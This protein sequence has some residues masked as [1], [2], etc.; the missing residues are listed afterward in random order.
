MLRGGRGLLGR[1]LAPGDW[2]SSLSQRV[3]E[4]PAFEQIL[5]RR[6]VPFRSNHGSLYARLSG[7]WVLVRM[8]AIVGSRRGHKKPHEPGIG[9]PTSPVVVVGIR[10]PA[11]HCI[12]EHAAR[13]ANL[14]ESSL[15]P[16]F[17]PLTRPT[18]SNPQNALAHP[19]PV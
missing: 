5:L 1:F 4:T 14:L 2:G 6:S 16:P 8:E 17:N 12:P 10:Q 18:S 13:I 3:G 9:N 19:L 11:S 7:G 15:G